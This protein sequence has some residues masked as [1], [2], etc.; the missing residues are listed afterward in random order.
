MSRHLWSVASALATL[1]LF[2]I[3]GFDF[4][5]RSFMASICAIAAAFAYTICFT[6][7]LWRVK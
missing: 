2:W 4:N 5:E 3:G 7:Q 6:C 1:A